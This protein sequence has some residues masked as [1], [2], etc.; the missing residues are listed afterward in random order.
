MQE[1]ARR[2]AV[3]D[4][5]G[6]GIVE[7]RFEPQERRGERGALPAFQKMILEVAPRLL[8]CAKQLPPRL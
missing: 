6:G 3:R 5:H 4:W 7:L 1:H 2:Q 8:G